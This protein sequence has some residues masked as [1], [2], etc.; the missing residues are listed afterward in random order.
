MSA[1][2]PLIVGLGLLTG[3]SSTQMADFF[4]RSVELLAIICS[5]IVF[6]ATRMDEITNITRKIR[7][8]KGAN[9]FVGLAMCLSGISMILL[10]IFAGSSEKGNVIPGLTIALL[11][12]IANTLFWRKYTV[13]NRQS[14]NAILA[15]QSRLYCAKAIVD[16][17][18]TLVLV[19]VALFPASKEA[20]LLDTVGSIIVAVYL[21]Y[22]GI[23]TI[24]ECLAM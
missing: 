23:R 2:G 19:T 3:K 22:C 9:L 11:G 10:S 4:R 21:I 15:V 5:F 7:M 12:V 20:A 1:P 14:P 13:L 18:V 24:S 17:C 8:E 6:Q 16:G